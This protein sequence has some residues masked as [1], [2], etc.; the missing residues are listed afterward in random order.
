MKPGEAAL[1]VFQWLIVFTELFDIDLQNIY[2]FLLLHTISFDK[3]TTV[4]L[5]LG[6]KLHI[7]LLEQILFH[8]RFI[9][10]HAQAIFILDTYLYIILLPH[11][12]TVF[13]NKWHMVIATVSMKQMDFSSKCVYVNLPYASR[14][15]LSLFKTNNVC[16]CD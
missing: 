9:H 8:W 6:G 3:L 4:D 13:R 14:L 15:N 12:G 10:K 1:N 2:G 16:Q 5:M 7:I 11:E